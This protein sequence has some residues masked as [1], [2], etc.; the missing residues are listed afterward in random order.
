[1]DETNGRDRLD[2]FLVLDNQVE[3]DRFGK[4]GMLRAKGN[5]G[6]GHGKAGDYWAAGCEA[7]TT[8]GAGAV[9]GVLQANGNFT[10]VL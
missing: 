2:N 8:A 7:D 6:A 1:M 10:A 4:N 5:D 3:M 9:S